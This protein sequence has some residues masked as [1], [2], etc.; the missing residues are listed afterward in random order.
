MKLYNYIKKNIDVIVLSFLICVNCIRVILGLGETTLMLYGLYLLCV[1]L[2]FVNYGKK[3]FELILKVKIFNSFFIVIV[4]IILY[5]S[6]SLIWIQSSEIIST[7]LKF[8]LSL[9]IGALA[10]AM[11]INKIK[12]AINYIVAINVIYAILILLYPRLA[13]TSMNNGLNYLNVTLPLG[14]A[15]TITLI[16]SMY[17]IINKSGFI[18]TAIWILFSA[19]FFVAMVGFVARGALL[20]PPLIAIMMFVFIKKEHKFI[21]W[22]LIPLFLGVLLLFYLY[23]MNNASDY[24]ISRMMRMMESTDEESRWDLWYAA[25]SDIVNRYWFIIGGGIDAFRYNSSIHFYPHNIFIQVIG[26]Y[27]ILG[28]ILSFMTLWS[29]IKGFLISRN[30]VIRYDESQVLYCL[31]GAYAYYTLTFSK[32]FSLYD[33]L[34]LFIIISFCLSLFYQLR[35]KSK[36][37]TPHN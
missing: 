14:L 19:L 10:V 25:L 20:F 2:L 28:I 15:L 7:Y 21:S 6:V 4:L 33:G 29:I 30:R 11:P 5:A 34:P 18:L 16:K 22:L 9:I 23:Y 27:G 3:L 17:L 31:I 8:V 13:E 1:I 32:S 35:V 36:A 26:E 24:A 37:V 12:I